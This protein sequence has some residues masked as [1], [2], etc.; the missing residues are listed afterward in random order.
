MRKKN[1]KK[2]D[3]ACSL[4]LGNTLKKSNSMKENEQ[5]IYMK[6]EIEEEIVQMRGCM[7]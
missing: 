7:G 2:Y 6:E 1:Q 3:G 4:E 5:I